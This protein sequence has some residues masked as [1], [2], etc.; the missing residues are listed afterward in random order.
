MGGGGGGLKDMALPSQGFSRLITS[1]APTSAG[2]R[3]G[4][5]WGIIK[6]SAFMPSVWVWLDR[7]ALKG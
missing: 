7:E 3:K 5:G 1:A 6:G 4:V 2:R